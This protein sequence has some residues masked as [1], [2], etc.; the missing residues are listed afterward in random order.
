MKRVTRVLAGSLAA[1]ALT[2]GVTTTVAPTA[3]ALL[4]EPKQDEPTP[5]PPP[6]TPTAFP[7]MYIDFDGDSSPGMVGNTCTLGV[8]GTDSAGRN[9]GITAGHCN[10]KT[11]QRNNTPDFSNVMIPK[12]VGAPRGVPVSDNDHPVYD[13]NAVLYARDQ[14]TTVPPIGWIRWVDG[15]V[16]KAGDTGPDGKKCPRD[17]AAEAITDMAT[18]YDKGYSDTDVN[19]NSRTDYTVIEFAPGVQLSSQ[20]LDKDGKAVTSTAG[21]G[22]LFK[23]N[24]VYGSNSAPA[25]P[26]PLINSIENFGA[27]SARVPWPAANAVAPN[28]GV[29]TSVTSSGIIYSLAGFQHGDSGG[30]VVMRGTGKW[31][32][33]ITATLGAGFWVNT[34]AK[35]ILDSIN[36]PDHPSTVGKGFTVTNN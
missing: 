34:S 9:V 21:G 4:A 25:L 26:T 1:L 5:Y 17:P 27:W 31:V 22:K 36:H 18:Y 23:V 12:Y 32:G 15:D 3:S 7:G 16:C 24:S 29:V 28:W 2:M 20:V 33:I 11:T 8:V 19:V 30:P 35:N 14:G 13:H 6:A 10:P